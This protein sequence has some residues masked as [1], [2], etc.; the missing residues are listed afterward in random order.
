LDVQESIR[1][2]QT[3]KNTLFPAETKRKMAISAGY[4]NIFTIFA[5]DFDSYVFSI[6]SCSFQK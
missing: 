2:A 1:L 5:A 4:R 6:I 3:I